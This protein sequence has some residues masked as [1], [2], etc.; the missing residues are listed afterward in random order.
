[1]VAN[2]N[3]DANTLERITGELDTNFIVEAGAG[4]GK[5]YAL[6]SRV[7]ALVKAGYQMGGI[8]AITFTEAAAAELSERIRSRIEQLLDDENSANEGD[9]LYPLVGDERANVERAL[10]DIDQAAIQ[11][12]HSFA[13]QLLQERPMEIGLPPG[14]APMDE[15][16]SAER[17]ADRWDEWKERAL[18]SDAPADLQDALRSLLLQGMGMAKWRETAEAFSGDDRLRDAGILG[19]VNLAELADNTLSELR[20]LA[21]LCVDPSDRLYKQLNGDLREGDFR[22]GAIPTVEAVLEASDSVSR[23]AV[24]LLDGRKVDYSGAVGTRNNWSVDP[25][26]VRA[27]FREVG[28]EFWRGVKTAGLPELL[29]DLQREFAVQYEDDRKAD[30]VAGFQDL[31]AWARDLLRD[32]EGVRGH[33][34]GKYSHILIDEFQD[35]DPLQAEIAFYLAAR[36]DAPIGKADWHTLPLERGKIFIVGD[37]KQSIYR[38]RRADIGV[39]R[40]VTDSG[41][42]ERLAIVQN[43]RSQSAVV[44]WV[45]AV[46]EKLMVQDGAQAV[47]GGAQAVFGDLVVQDGAQNVWD[48]VQAAF[49]KQSDWDN[50]KPQP[51]VQAEYIP[52]VAH[53]D[54]QIGKGAVRVFGGASRDKADDVRRQQARDVAAIVGGVGE[55]RVYDKGKKCE[56]K[57]ERRDVCV[58]VRSRT[59]LGIL[60]RGLED[61]GIPYRLEGGSL[62]FDTQEVRDMLNC[63]RA[64]D[65][66]TDEVSV[67][68]ALRSPAFA[69]SDVDLMRWREGGGW[70]DYLARGLDGKAQAAGSRVGDGLVALRDYH[71]GR[72]GKST[73]QLIAEFTRDRRLDE[74]DLAEARPREAW[75][76]RRFLLEEARAR[77]AAGANTL[78]QFIRWAARQQEEGAQIQQPDMPDGDEDAVRIMTMHGSK[79]LEFP[80]VILLGLDSAGGG[81]R[82]GAAVQFD[83]DTN[84]VEVAF[85]KDFRTPG[86][87]ALDEGE[88][89][90]SE[91]EAVR[92]AYVAATRAR[93]YLYVSLHHR[94]GSDGA[95]KDDVIAGKIQEMS[96]DLPHTWLDLSEALPVRDAAAASSDGAMLVD[97][98]DIDAWRARR[99]AAIDKSSAALAVTATRVARNAAGRPD[100]WGDIEDKEG[101]PDDER[102]WLAGRGGTAMGSAVHA[103][104]QSALELMSPRLPLG[105]GDDLDGLVAGYAAEIGRLADRHAAY[106]GVSDAGEVRRLTGDA[107]AHDA[108]G[109]ALRARRRWS[110]ISVAAPLDVDGRAV[111]LE[112]IIDLLY[113]TDD[114]ELVVL[115]YKTDDVRSARDLERKR[116]RYRYQ[117]ACYAYAVARATGKRVRAVQFLFIRRARAGDG[118]QDVDFRELLDELPGLVGGA[119]GG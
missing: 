1:M 103:T 7:V 97:D 21:E 61:A 94:A 8:V 113:E 89:R 52:L 100:D 93:D 74:L 83:K 34:Q 46:F 26:V 54:H 24:A 77:D 115:D 6:V 28:R 96:D 75:R 22:K 50:A 17:F 105:A 79:G 13:A 40:L 37:P 95:P 106:Y 117:G 53:G 91:A 66:P 86:Y 25:K 88:K 29:R 64:I 82:G 14:W 12:I 110:E 72:L 114:G 70:W 68:A 15:I 10:D 20:G 92:L 42:L 45:N 59:G 49:E 67:V 84:S 107:L 33:F 90:H 3:N 32:N 4:T 108:V 5:T 57:A 104:L 38:F 31:L 27:R 41:R 99:A 76:R 118:L 55:L 9:A 47:R 112:G 43:R 63:L 87:D 116:A 85:S 39:T 35:T 111:A 2:N 51:Q 119:G 101:E 78:N 81:S 19:K 56:R 71:N 73:A 36:A 48:G 69:C 16:D 58:L 65:D 62:L 109:E 11:T 23:A 18:G 80:I 60:E 30:G 98:Y 44:D 102:P